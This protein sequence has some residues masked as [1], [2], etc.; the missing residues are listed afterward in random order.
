MGTSGRIDFRLFNREKRALRVRLYLAGAGR[1]LLRDDKESKVSFPR[2][3]GVMK[4][5]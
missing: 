5:V 1:A 4:Q 3:R 2:G